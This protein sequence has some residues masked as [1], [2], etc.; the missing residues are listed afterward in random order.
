MAH[1]KRAYIYKLLFYFNLQSFNCFQKSVFVNIGPSTL[2]SGGGG[3]KSLEPRTIKIPN[4][5]FEIISLAVLK[6]IL[7]QFWSHSP[8]ISRAFK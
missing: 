1:D 8:Y 4:L 2:P 3:Q 6:A 5:I 7:F